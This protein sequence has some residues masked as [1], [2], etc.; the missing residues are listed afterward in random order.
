[1]NSRALVWCT[2]GSH[3]GARC[4]VLLYVHSAA[5]LVTLEASRTFCKAMQR[6]PVLVLLW[7]GQYHHVRQLSYTHS[8][9]LIVKIGW[10]FV[11]PCSTA[12]TV[13]HL[14]AFWPLPVEVFGLTVS[15]ARCM[16][17]TEHALPS[18]CTHEN[19]KQGQCLEQTWCR[20]ETVVV[21]VC[22]NCFLHLTL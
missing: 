6:Q 19:K 8:P 12:P 11:A 14:E 21:V 16:F 5:R 4:A 22:N 10:L 7:F 13:Y 18:H 20:L 2:Q 1:M 3:S 17:P 15:F 9:T